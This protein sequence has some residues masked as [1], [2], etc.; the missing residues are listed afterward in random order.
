M[1]SLLPLVLIAFFLSLIFTALVRKVGRHFAFY[2]RDEHG[3]KKTRL[4]TTFG[5]VGIYLASWLTVYYYNPIFFMAQRQVALFLASSLVLLT[6]ILDDWRGLKPWQ[7]SLGI[8]VSASIIFAYSDISFSTKLLPNLSPFYYQLISYLL[9]VVWIYLVTNAIN[10]IDGLDGLAST[11]TL[12]SLI[13]LTVTTFFFSLSISLPIL[14]LL[15][16]LSGALAGFI[17]YNWYPAEIYLGDTGALFIGFMYA[18]LSVT[19]LKN[20]SFYSLIV[21]VLIYS[22]PLANTVFAILRR[23]LSGQSVVQA[24]HDHIHQRLLRLGLKEWQVVL[25]MAVITLVFS[26][27]AILTQ[28]FVAERQYILLVTLILVVLIFIPM[29]KLT[30]EGRLNRSS[31]KGDQA[32]DKRKK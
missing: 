31:N 28:A 13:T 11:V 22:L 27:L 23:L 32:A 3:I 15:L 7:K 26:I 21:P 29:L 18:S 20:A 12:I 14:V 10:L 5:G 8:L 6:G 16:V 4:V 25:V 9:T 19:H 1:E 2:D 30:Q 17:P 24:D